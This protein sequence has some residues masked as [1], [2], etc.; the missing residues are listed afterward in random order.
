MWTSLLVTCICLPSCE[1]RGYS[2]LLKSCTFSH[3]KNQNNPSGSHL[4]ILYFSYSEKKQK[5]LQKQLRIWKWMHAQTHTTNTPQEEHTS[6]IHRPECACILQMEI[7]WWL[8]VEELRAPL[9]DC[10]V[11]PLSVRGRAFSLSQSH[12]FP[13]AT[14]L[15]WYRHHIQMASLSLKY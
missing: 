9:C 2:S 10:S 14:R 6:F 11:V 13:H 15:K 5:S 1:Q 7:R 3:S 12:V 8:S 4:Y